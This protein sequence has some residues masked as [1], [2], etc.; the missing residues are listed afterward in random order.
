MRDAA[1]ERR[2]AWAGVAQAGAFGRAGAAGVTARL[3]D[4]FALAGVIA[5]AGGEA[6]LSRA[7]EARFGLSP[8]ARPRC[9]EA[10][11]HALIW[12]GP[13]QWLL[14]A[15]QRAG[16]AATRAALEPFAAVSD[17]SDARA[18]LRIGGPRARDVLARGVMIDLDPRA[19]A[20]GDVAMT[21]IAHVNLHL[22][23]AQDDGDP[24]YELLVPRSLAASF[25][26]WFA[27]SAAQFGCAVSGAPD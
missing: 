11:G 3:R 23:R 6:A 18:G 7:L 9:V 24:T 2:G 14:R 10:N 17:Q 20:V 15:D 25:W 21:S 1:W 22:W 5:A 27:A 26:S 13:G 4:G 16:F 19:F 8:P 12:S